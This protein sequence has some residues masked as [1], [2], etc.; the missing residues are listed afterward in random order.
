VLRIRI[1]KDPHHFAGS[2]NLDTDPVL[3]YK[4]VILLTF[5]L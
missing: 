2:G 1:R 4:I 3:G 5:L